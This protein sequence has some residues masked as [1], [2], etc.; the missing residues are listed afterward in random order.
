MPPRR[1]LFTA[2]KRLAKADFADFTGIRVISPVVGGPRNGRGI[3]S[4]YLRLKIVGKVGKVGKMHSI[5]LFASCLLHSR[6]AAFEVIRSIM[7]G[8]GAAD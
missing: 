8:C 3:L 4:F 1:R 6:F 2:L 5:E 7:A